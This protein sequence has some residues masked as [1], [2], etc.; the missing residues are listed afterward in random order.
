MASPAK[1]RKAHESRSNRSSNKKAKHASSSEG[2][3]DNSQVT[4]VES[5]VEER[6]GSASDQYWKV[7]DIIGERSNQY[8][9]DWD[10]LDPQTGK[11]YKPTWEPKFYVTKAAIA[12]WEKRKQEKTVSS[13]RATGQSSSP[14][15]GTTHST[16][17]RPSR[18]SSRRLKLVIGSPFETTDRAQENGA[19]D[20]SLVGAHLEEEEI[21]DSFEKEKGIDPIS[22]Q[23][24]VEIDQHSS[25]DRDQYISYSSA[26]SAPVPTSSRR[27]G[28]HEQQKQILQQER[29]EASVPVVFDHEGIVPDSQSLPGSSSFLPSASKSN[30]NSTYELP[31]SSSREIITNTNEET[32]SILRESSPLSLNNDS[33]FIQHLSSPAIPEEHTNGD[34]R[35]SNSGRSVTP[36]PPTPSTGSPHSLA[37]QPGLAVDRNFRSPTTPVEKGVQEVIAAEADTESRDNLLA[38]STSLPSPGIKGVDAAEQPQ[39]AGSPSVENNPQ[40]T[41]TYEFLQ[42]PS[43]SSAIPEHQVSSL[44]QPSAEGLSGLLVARQDFGAKSAQSDHADSLND[45]NQSSPNLASEG[46]TDYN[47]EFQT[48]I[49]FSHSTSTEGSGIGDNV[50]QGLRTS[51]SPIP[52]RDFTENRLFEPVLESGDSSGVSQNTSASG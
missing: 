36:N 17:V 40:S 32:P 39:I 46:L 52:R 37:C 35:H 27:E 28:L 50:S 1:K 6:E 30:S 23:L 12:A 3:S 4:R 21:E 13:R 48:Q 7:K 25:F 33:G 49:A 44:F 22:Q 42:K 16:P 5:E 41:L 14:A 2:T 51:A 11:K 15:L 45:H 47:V 24:L 43:V 26:L 9:I 20:P 31:N 34:I 18:R 19:G 29:Q 10:G 8:R 38:A